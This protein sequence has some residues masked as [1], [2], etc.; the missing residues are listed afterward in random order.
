MA[1]DKKKY[2]KDRILTGTDLVMFRDQHGFT[3]DLVC[4][5]L[6]LTRQAYKKLVDGGPIPNHDVR[7]LLRY[8]IENP[9]KV[10]LSGIATMEDAF[11]AVNAEIGADNPLNKKEFAALFGNQPTASIRW[12]NYG[13][14]PS[15]TI[16]NLL[17]LAFNEKNPGRILFSLGRREQQLQKMLDKQIEPQQSVHKSSTNKKK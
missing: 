1:N 10:P 15:R 16:Q 4:E 13:R 17:F 9:D 2:Q 12:L 14:S 5:L 11:D 3:H 7:M 6:G 8:Y